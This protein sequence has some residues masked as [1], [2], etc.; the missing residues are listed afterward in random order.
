MPHGNRR[1]GRRHSEQAAS[2]LG[3]GALIGVG[4]QADLSRL[5]GVLDAATGG[6]PVFF[7]SRYAGL[8]YLITDMKNRTPFDF[9]YSTVFGRKGQEEVASLAQGRI[10]FL[11]IDTAEDRS[12]PLFPQL[13]RTYVDQSMDRYRNLGIC[14][15]HRAR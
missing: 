3:G 15:L 9:P 7:V 2:S 5:R 1:S 10:L 14:T 8:Y 4:Q 13:I 12:A 6:R 11:C